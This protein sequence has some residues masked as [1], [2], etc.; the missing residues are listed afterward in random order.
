MVE[1]SRCAASAVSPKFP[2]TFRGPCTT[3][4]VF[5]RLFVLTAYDFSGQFLRLRASCGLLL[6]SAQSILPH[7]VTQ[8]LWVH[9][10]QARRTPLAIDHPIGRLQRLH[11][12]L[13][14]IQTFA[15][16]WRGLHRFLNTPTNR[17]QQ[18]ITNADHPA[19]AQQNRP[20]DQML[21]LAHIP[22][23]S[24]PLQVRD[25]LLV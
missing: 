8:L 5:P 4:R 20:M 19:L 16:R 10:Q 14:F 21:Q 2:T 25:H 9:A 1:L 24:I 23:P 11:K 13:L 17:R 7:A 18:Q 12:L 6:R 3:F 22:R 15:S